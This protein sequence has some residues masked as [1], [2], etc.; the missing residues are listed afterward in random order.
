[1]SIIRPNDALLAR[2]VS[3]SSWSAGP[4]TADDAELWAGFAGAQSAGAFC[5]N[6]LAL[7]CGELPGAINGL[8]LLQE[9]DGRYT[10]AAIWPDRTRDLGHLARIAQDALVKRAGVT[11]ADPASSKVAY[12]IE[13]TGRLQGVVVMELAGQTEDELIV[14]LR[15]LHW[16]AGW[17]ETLFR[18]HDADHSKARLAQSDITLDLLS[19]AAEHSDQ[20]QAATA[21]AT[22]L[23]SRL[24]CSRVSVGL[25]HGRRVRLSAMSFQAVFQKQAQIVDAIENAME[26]ALD[27]DAAVAWPPTPGTARR[28]GLAQA[29]LGRQAG[30]RAVASVPLV[31]AGRPVGVV[32]LE[33]DI[34][35]SF[36]DDELAQIA[37]VSAAIGPLV[38]AR[39]KSQRLIAGKAVDK[40][41]AG[42]QKLVGPRRPGL[43]IAAAL[44]LGAV[45][46]LLLATGEF[47]LSARSVIEGTVKRSVVAP[48]DGF[49]ASA[50]LRAGDMV[51]AGDVMATL[52]DRDLRLDLAQ[53]VAERDK[54]RLKYQEALGKQDRTQARVL[55]AQIREAEAQIALIETKLDRARITAPFAG[56]VV[57]GDLTQMLG[58]P[59]ETGK[60]MFE[61]A[62]LNS[63]RAILQLEERDM[64]FIREGQTGT[65][66]LAGR[67]SEPLPVAITKIVPVA[68]AQ[69]GSNTFRVEAALT[70][71]P[72]WVRPG[73]EGVSKI[74]VNRSGLLWIWTR[75]LT[76]WA[77]LALW[78]WWP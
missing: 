56:I 73:M 2:A 44:L 19:V 24:N 41:G 58:A 57:S 16:G 25:S 29:D 55:S 13:V 27:Q 54:Q 40:A 70:D 23:A 74:V 18:R 59:V 42:I 43:K 60:I 66:L 48:F 75:S 47:R 76:D 64:S 6:W 35:T 4:R 12:P 68:T 63:Y 39:A 3:A 49:V 7:Q 53:K 22:S 65:L 31:S 67:A 28:I 61:L 46:W 33:R 36:S 77:R 15:R 11:E 20:R 72:L 1:M 14:A 17:L 32:T 51:A 38:E 37:A 52:D 69:N 30:V 71:V 78:K 34:D 5:E 26:E 9:T 45:I 50:A 21:V 10:P 62:P 8:L